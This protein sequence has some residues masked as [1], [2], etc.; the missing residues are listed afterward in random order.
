MKIEIN[1]NDLFAY[2]AE[3]NVLHGCLLGFGKSAEEVKKNF[4]NLELMRER[5]NNEMKRFEIVK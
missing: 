2:H 5:V 1:D 4:P 3:L